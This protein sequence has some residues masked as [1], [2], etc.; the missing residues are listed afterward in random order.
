M[1]AANYTAFVERMINRYEGGYGWDRGDPG[2][3]TK[4][5]ITCYDLA[6]H[7]GEHMDS[8]TRWAPLVRAMSLHEADDI[9][10]T[11]YAVQCDFNSLNAGCDCV[12]FDF[13]VNSGSSRSIRYAQEV[14][15]VHIDGVLGP[16]TQAAINAFD[17][18]QFVNGLCNA[19][20][21]FLRGLRMWATFGRGWS[22]RVFD[23]RKYS[24]TLIPTEPEHMKLRR[25]KPKVFEPKEN[26]IPRAHPKAYH[27]DELAALKRQHQ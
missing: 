5:G 12:V 8:M 24:L 21:S 27:A 14:V 17:S 1:T 10:R 6:E 4:Y 18:H 2:G 11:K 20:L 9:Y 23:L 26:R 7:R 19:R 3:P 25:A 22:A 16:E 15:K 13:G